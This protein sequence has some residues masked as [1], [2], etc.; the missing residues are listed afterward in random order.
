M[1]AALNI[2]TTGLFKETRLFPRIKR[3]L[4][5]L[6]TTDTAEGIYSNIYDLSP[7]GIQ[8]RCD[9]AMAFKINPAGLP[10][11]KKKLVNVKVSFPLPVADD[12][13]KIT[14]NCEVSYMAIV[15]DNIDEQFAI[16]L[17][18]KKEKGQVVSSVGSYIFD[19]IA[20][21]SQD[22]H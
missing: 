6:I 4:P 20:Q 21:P 14:I 2:E 9:R 12:V 16:G 22:L 5:V 3:R 11:N 10:L 7:E 15:P 13:V 18:F 8:I 17:T 19:E 1:D